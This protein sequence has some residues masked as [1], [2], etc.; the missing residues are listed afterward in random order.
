MQR[1]IGTIDPNDLNSE[2]IAW[3][4]FVSINVSGVGVQRYTDSSDDYT[5]DID[6][7]SQTWTAWD[8]SVGNL[9]QGSQS[10]V[11]VSWIEVA[12]L[13]ETFSTWANS[14]GLRNADVE[15]WY[16]QF[17]VATD[18]LVDSVPMYVGRIDNH[19]IGPRAYLALKP[20]RSTWARST[21]T[22]VP[23]QSPLLPAPLMPKDGVTI[24]WNVAT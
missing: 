12:N 5:G 15:V 2:R 3:S 1:N 14:P 7:S 24:Y 23:G 18:A 10:A 4:W 22:A 6:G 9:D 13:D 21:F 11:S 19:R 8:L 16:A 20:G 17:D